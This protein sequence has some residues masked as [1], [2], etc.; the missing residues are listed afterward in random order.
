[1]PVSS[2]IPPQAG[3]TWPQAIEFELV[4]DSLAEALERR[5]AALEYALCSPLARRRLRRHI[6]CANRGFAWAGPSF[7]DQRLEAT[8]SEWLSGSCAELTAGQR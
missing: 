1:M 3:P 7:W 4:T 8:T 5:V 2:P 6:R